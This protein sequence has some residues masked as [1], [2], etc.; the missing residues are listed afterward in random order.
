MIRSKLK[1]VAA[2]SIAVLGLTLIGPVGPASASTYQ[3]F[4]SFGCGTGNN[5]RI[6]SDTTGNVQ[7]YRN[8]ALSAYWYGGATRSVHYSNGTR[9]LTTASVET[10][11]SNAWV[12]SANVYCS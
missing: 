8:N 5:I 1:T 7:H 11:T 3:D 6:S 2:A 4:Y 10:T 9:Y 12:Y